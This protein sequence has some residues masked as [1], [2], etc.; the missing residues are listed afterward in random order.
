MLLESLNDSEDFFS[1]RILEDELLIY[2]L[3]KAKILET[4]VEVKRKIK[5]LAVL[6]D[7]NNREGGNYD[8]GGENVIRIAESLFASNQSLSKFFA[9]IL[10]PENAQ[11]RGEKF[12]QKLTQAFLMLGIRIVVRDTLGGRGIRLS[13]EGDL[14]ELKKNKLAEEFVEMI[15]AVAK[16]N[17]EKLLEYCRGGQIENEV[18]ELVLGVNYEDDVLQ[19]RNVDLLYRSGME[20]AGVARFGSTRPDESVWLSANQKLWPEVTV[21]DLQ[22]LID[23]VENSMD[24]DFEKGFG[25]E[26]I[27]LI[28]ENTFLKLEKESRFSVT[29]PYTGNFEDAEKVFFEIIFDERNRELPLNICLIAD[30]KF[31]IY[32][33]SSDYKLWNFVIADFENVKQ[34]QVTAVIA[35]NQNSEAFKLPDQ[36]RL[37]IGYANVFTATVEPED[38]S[39]KIKTA[40][41]FK[42]KYI[43]WKGGE[44]KMNKAEV[45]IEDISQTAEFRKYY[46]LQGNFREVEGCSLEEIAEKILTK[47]GKSVER[48]E[49]FNLLAD[50]FVAKM[51]IWVDSLKINWEKEVQ[52]RALI[53]YHLTSFF[54]ACCP[55]QDG[56]LPEGWEKSAQYIGRYMTLVY[57]MD[58][59]I[60]DCKIEDGE[61]KRNLMDIATEQFSRA[62]QLK[63]VENIHSEV[64]IMEI[65]P[66]ISDEFKLLAEDLSREGEAKYFFQW[67][68][69]MVNLFKCHQREWDNKAYYDTLMESDDYEKKVNEFVLK[70]GVMMNSQLIRKK[71]ERCLSELQQVDGDKFGAMC[72]LKL[73]GYLF[74]IEDSIGAGLV[75]RTVAC[76]A[77]EQAENPQIVNLYEEICLLI[78]IYFRLANDFAEMYRAGDD[79][80]ENQDSRSMI[81]PKYARGLSKSEALIHSS[82]EIYVL[83]E[84][85]KKEIMKKREEFQKICKNVKPW[86]GVALAIVRSDIAELYYKGTHYREASREQVEGFFEKLYDLGVNY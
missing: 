6:A 36:G 8:K 57:L 41:D 24:L 67:Q 50:L 2:I 23:R 70:Y 63:D 46:D 64:K 35:P 49:K 45:N 66:V 84:D 76:F 15:M 77:K 11:K 30:D 75:Y 5:N 73:Y 4:R 68:K 26:E 69:A 31:Q 27:K 54:L 40:I 19:R 25:I 78:N 7:G 82:A 43:A 85:F 58:D 74:D 28:I 37:N 12:F 51:L 22:K 56:K 20:E 1:R 72:D 53:N 81:Y 62:V 10:S 39:E 3:P 14:E 33:T 21:S 80:E 71:V 83:I 29:I 44:R 42:K 52:F 34:N 55:D 59:R 17:E 18:K 86:E 13:Y 48:L 60:Y 65:I 61:V 16:I 32:S 9:F 79:R 47:K 38:I